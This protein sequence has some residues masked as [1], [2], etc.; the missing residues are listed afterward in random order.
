MNV[1]SPT[2]IEAA[3]SAL[4]EIQA[5]TLVEEALAAGDSGREV[6]RQVQEGMRLVGQRYEKKEIYLAGLI[7]A[8]EIFHGAMQLAQPRLEQ[9]P[10]GDTSARVLL[11]TVQGDIHDLGK[12][13]LLMLLRCYG[14][15]VLDLGVDVA[16]AKFVEEARRMYQA[17]KDHPD[18]KINWVRDSTG[19]V[20]AKLLAE[21][22][23]PQ[24]DVVWGLAATSLMLL[25]TEGMLEPYA[26][27]GVENLDP[28]F[29][30]S[31][32]PPQWTGMD[33][34]I[35]A[36][37]LYSSQR[38]RTS[39]LANFITAMLRMPVLLSCPTGRT[40]R[41]HLTSVMNGFER[42]D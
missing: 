20:T 9:E 11:G 32:S 23:N 31:S 21:K 6:I 10:A 34:W 5:L 35:A 37:C 2:P 36:I 24:A 29:V 13:L 22:N 30:D 1:D 17:N 4:D 26:P 14:F 8:G 40:L 33:A 25:K 27:K 38:L 12:N 18:I 28:K 3:V 19:V 7:M 39:S 15:T 16:P 41:I 42:G